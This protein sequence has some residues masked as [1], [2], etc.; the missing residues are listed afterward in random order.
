MAGVGRSGSYFA[1]SLGTD[2]QVWFPCFTQRHDGLF[3]LAPVGREPVIGKTGDPHVEVRPGA[4]LRQGGSF[5]VLADGSRAGEDQ[6]RHTH[7]GGGLAQHTNGGACSDRDVVAV[8]P[9]QHQVVYR[10]EDHGTVTT[11][12]RPHGT[13]PEPYIAS[14]CARS[15][16]VS[17]GSQ[18]PS[19][20]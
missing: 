5:L 11:P 18:N 20:R 7:P 10:F 1:I 17:A 12:R 8:R 9:R 2:H 3:H 16:K 19:C 6:G 15:L 14:R 4:Q 13:F